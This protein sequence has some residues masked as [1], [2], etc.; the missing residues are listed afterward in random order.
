MA[1]DNS[2]VISVVFRVNCARRTP[3]GELGTLMSGV[4]RVQL[5]TSLAIWLI[6]TFIQQNIIPG[7]FVFC[8]ILYCALH[9]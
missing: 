3:D 4:R 6:N 8:K 7:I 5:V 9:F 1:P 2:Y